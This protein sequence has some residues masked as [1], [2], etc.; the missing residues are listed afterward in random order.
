MALITSRSPEEVSVNLIP[1]DVL[2]TQKTH[3]WFQFAIAGAIT[4]VAILAVI[5]VA[6]RLQIAHQEDVLRDEQAKRAAL[7]AQVD[8]LRDIE[9]LKADIDS[10]RAVL[11]AALVGDVNWAKFLEDLDSNMPVDSSL[12]SLSVTSAAGTTPMG[13][14]TFG[15]AQYSGVVNSMPGLANWLETMSKITGLRFVY[16]S[17]GSKTGG[18]VTFGASAHLT[19]QMLSGRCQQEASKCP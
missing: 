11:A 19:E 9:I 13:E 2:S 4:V 15:S 1:Q 7:Q 17:N 12:T 5:V 10:T 8:A 6:Y 14:P 18:D 3:R 16:L